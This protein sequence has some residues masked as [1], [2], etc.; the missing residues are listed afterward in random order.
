[1]PT[2]IPELFD[3]IAPQNAEIRTVTNSLPLNFENSAKSLFF[4]WLNQTDENLKYI[5]L[6]C[7]KYLK[8]KLQKEG[9]ELGSVATLL[10]LRSPD[11]KMRLSNMFDYRHFHN[12]ACFICGCS[13]MGRK[14]L[15]IKFGKL[16]PKY[17]MGKNSP[18]VVLIQIGFE[19]H[20]K[21]CD[22]HLFLRIRNS[23]NFFYLRFIQSTFIN[24]YL[25]ADI[26]YH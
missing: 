25:V 17:H 9:N 3:S 21:F 23:W 16:V 4:N 19:R 12:K 5:R 14:V 6:H 2:F 22:G 13:K 26:F 8:A 10:K 15:V 1:M 20:R 7:W 18:P 24:H 11:E